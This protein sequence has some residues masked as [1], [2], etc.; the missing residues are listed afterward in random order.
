[1]SARMNDEREEGLLAQSSLFGL[2]SSFSF[3]TWDSLSK[4]FE[5]LR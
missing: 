3:L 4:T 2:P 5:A 1:M